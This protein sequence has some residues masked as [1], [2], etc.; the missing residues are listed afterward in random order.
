MENTNKD[1]MAFYEDLFKE[2]EDKKAQ[3]NLNILLNQNKNL[4]SQEVE[5]DLNDFDF[6]KIGNQ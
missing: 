6:S 1:L 3:E 5:Q 4:S 2:E